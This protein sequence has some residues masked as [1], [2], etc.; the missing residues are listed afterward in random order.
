MAVACQEPQLVG[1]QRNKT[2]LTCPSN[3]FVTKQFDGQV[4]MALLKQ[5]KSCF[6]YAAIVIVCFISF[7]NCLF[8]LTSINFFFNN[9]NCVIGELFYCFFFLSFFFFFFY[10]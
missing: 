7:F 3:C 5:W 6:I 10:A 1:F 9:F 4:R 2:I 8:F